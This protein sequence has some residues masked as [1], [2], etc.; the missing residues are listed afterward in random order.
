MTKTKEI[1]TKAGV[2][3]V[4]KDSITYGDHLDLKDV[5][6]E[7][8]GK[9]TKELSREADKKGIELVVVSIDGK[10]E[11]IF[12]EFKKLNYS[13]IAEVNTEIKGILNPK[14]E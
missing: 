8:E 5:Y 7:S 9:S 2:K 3:F 4:L 6:L 11:N 1:T 13:D 12:E 14:K 10:T